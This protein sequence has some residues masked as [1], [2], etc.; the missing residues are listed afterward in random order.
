MAATAESAVESLLGRLSSMLL[1]EAQLLK[2]VKGDVQFIKDE[3]E[4]MNGFLLD[5]AGGGHQVRAWTK[6]V[7][8]VACDSQNCIDRYVQTLGASRP[9]AGLLGSL[10]QVPKLVKTMPDRYRIAKQIR[11]LKGR[12]REVGERRQRYGVKAPMQ[13]STGANG[14]GDGATKT[15]LGDAEDARRRRVLADVDD[16]LNNDARELMAWL[17]RSERHDHTPPVYQHVPKFFKNMYASTS[18]MDDLLPEYHR[19]FRGIVGDE[20]PENIADAAAVLTKA[21]IDM[22]K[23]EIRMVGSVVKKEMIEAEALYTTQ[24]SLWLTRILCNGIIHELAG[25]GVFR[26]LAAALGGD[27]GR[28]PRLL[29]VVTPPVDILNPEEDQLR[30]HKPATELV[31]RVYDNAK[32]AKHFECMAWVDARLHAQ[33]KQRLQCI[34]QQLVHPSSGE[35]AQVDDEKELKKKIQEHLKGKKFL[36]VLADHDDLTPWEDITLTDAL[37]T[38]YS[39]DSAIIVTP[40]MQHPVQLH[41]WYA[42]SWFFLGRATHYKVHFYSHLDALNKKANELLVGSHPRKDE[43]HAIVKQILKKCRWDAFSTKM[44]LQALYANPHRSKAELETLLD[45]IREFNTVPNARNIIR[46]CYDDLPSQYKACLLYLSIFPLGSKI[47]RTS[48]VRRWAAENIITKRYDLSA[49]DEGDRAFSALLDRGLLLPCRIDPADKVKSCTVHHHVL[50]FIAEMARED[51]IGN[52]LLPLALSRRLSIRNGIQVLELSKKQQG[53]RSNACWRFHGS[54]RSRRS[55]DSQGPLDDMVTFLNVLHESPR[56]GLI[57][58]LDLEDC[59]GLKNRNLKNICNKIFQLKYLSARKTSITELPKEISKLQDL[60]TLDIRET[61]IKSFPAKAT[62]PPKLVHLLAG[63]I[64]RPSNNDTGSTE[65]YSTIHMPPGIGSMTNME[66]LSHVAVSESADELQHVGQLQ[67][68]RKL[69]LVIH[70]NS[71]RL[72]SI[73]LRVIWKL[74]CLYSLSVHIEAGGKDADMNTKGITISPPKSLERLSISGNIS[75]LPRWIEE[76]PQLSKI[77]LCRTSLTESDIQFLG[78]LVNLRYIRLRH[79]SYTPKKLTF[80]EKEFK[81]LEFLIIEGT[82]ISDITFEQYAASQL[83]KMVWTPTSMVKLC[84]LEHLLRLQMVKINGNCNMDDINMEAHPNH[85]ILEIIEAN[86]TATAS[87]APAL[88]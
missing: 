87:N 19:M 26:K 66:I 15:K 4:S 85:P 72:L 76:L 51:N 20:N 5:V 82:I 13:S 61:K 86:A 7:R 25:K 34:L 38:D 10:Q 58:V 46:L 69:G 14:A 30:T 1:D 24:V 75:E 12:A 42:A 43:V 49:M 36:I 65:S 29:V 83:E 16:L 55:E 8:E 45:S 52:T 23:H 64:Y 47:R 81:R 6:Q 33:R 80:K 84:G 70:G 31:R 32:K 2:G 54:S 77:T 48:L 63:D 18:K 59:T 3:T 17:I 27:R 50:S 60:E 11:E 67:R 74:E 79:E 56:L 39:E 35:A 88:Q 73:L 9:S 22:T 44:V 57:K 41:V 78:K 62:L 21:G 37:P 68:L 40:S 71:D 28:L 53:T